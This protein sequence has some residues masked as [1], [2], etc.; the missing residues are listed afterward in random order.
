MPVQAAVFKLSA[1]GAMLNKL[2]GIYFHLRASH[3][4]RRM[5]LEEALARF[6]KSIEV[7]PKSAAAFNDRALVYLHLRNYEQALHDAQK[8]VELMP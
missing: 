8:A 7:A 2:R 3:S 5:K 4:L 1:G 6:N